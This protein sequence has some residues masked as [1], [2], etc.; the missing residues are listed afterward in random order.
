[1][2]DTLP[3][4]PALP[5]V[6][7]AGPPKNPGLDYAW[8]KAEGTRLVQ[9]SAGKVWTDYNESDPGVT[10]L[11]QLCYA[12]TELSYRAEL[13]LEDLL[14]GG[15]GEAIDPRRQAL[16]PARDIF[17]VEPFT[18]RDYRKLLVDRIAPV[19][20]A[21]ITPW[22]P[23]ARS[24]R[25]LHGLWD[26]LLYVPSLDPDCDPCEERKV[27]DRARQVYCAHRGLC[28]DLRSV[29]V[30]RQEP[31]AVHGEVDLDRGASPDR[32]LADLLFRLGLLFAPEPR[33]RPLGELVR[34]GVQPSAIF[35]GP[36]LLHGFIA[37]AELQ[38][39][40]SSIAVQDVVRTMVG[41]PGVA[42][43]RRAVVVAGGSSYGGN[44]A[45]PVGRR[46]ILRLEARAPGGGY[47]LR[48]FCRGV[49]VKPDRAKV[50][51][52]LRRLRAE[53]RRR[54]PLE[55]EY[56]DHFAFPT[57]RFRDVRHYYSVQNQYPA[58]YGINAYGLPADALPARQAQAK[59]LKGYLLPFEQLLADELAQLAHARDLF[60][61]LGPEHP[62]GRRSY[63]YQSLERDV[64]N[65]E[66]LFRGGPAAYRQG[67]R[68]LVDAADPWVR[69]RARFL[70]FLLSLYADGVGEDAVVPPDGDP[71][72]GGSPAGEAPALLRARLELLRRLVETT[73]RRA[74]GFD[75]L[76]RPGP[77]NVSGME[78]R[79]RIQLGMPLDD[80]RPLSA[81]LGEAGAEL[82]AGG[83]G[84]AGGLEWHADTVEEA[85]EPVAGEA[86]GGWPAGCLGALSES[87]LD[88]PPTP[89]DLR[90]GTFPGEA[91]V[92]AVYRAGGGWRL[93]GKFPDRAAAAAAARGFA[94]MLARLRLHARQLY[95]V[96][97]LLLRAG[98]CRGEPC[99][100]DYSFSLTAV[101]FLPPRLLPDEAYRAFAREVV[102]AAAPAH[103]AVECC[104]LGFAQGRDFEGLYAAWR[105]ALERGERRRL[106]EASARLRD[107]LCRCRGPAEGRA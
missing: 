32:V 63:W 106:R 12:L 64:P 51:R 66:P 30:L 82:R 24:P 103:L 99:G 70:A 3:A 16:Y 35:E 18:E 4:A 94:G 75:Y 89:G 87:F 79:V 67:L 8:L 101:F 88:A 36:L 19:A 97:H 90:I 59:Q 13:P 93:L 65:V 2:T 15:P 95:L 52:E 81:V 73:A 40:A 74:R 43:V 102:R 1:M 92:S 14:V 48:L 26:L 68:E 5:P 71:C 85:F 10:T 49:E 21:W 62:D 28:E 57:G 77:G 60:S 55:E 47:T 80:R 6:L 58:V 69:R 34:A 22:R 98:R 7:P 27:L 86:E 46:S 42:G 39:K 96:E 31:V 78:V 41:T 76:R 29:A 38:P 17:P 91:A 61:T 54:Y 53:H 44:E 72:G 25:A 104:F 45:V 37:D 50:E 84:D 107:F 23:D 100:F 11:E 105:L 83:P 20:N 9:E 33:R 56:A